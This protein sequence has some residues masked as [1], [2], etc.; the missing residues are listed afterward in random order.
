MK[1]IVNAIMESAMPVRCDRAAMS[2]G[3]AGKKKITRNTT[4]VIV[5]AIV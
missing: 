1:A 3:S 2:D 4:E 5:D